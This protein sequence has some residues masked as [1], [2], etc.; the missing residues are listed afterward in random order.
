MQGT[1]GRTKTRSQN[2]I[3]FFTVNVRSKKER[4]VK[5][6]FIVRFSSDDLVEDCKEARKNRPPAS[7]RCGPKKIEPTKYYTFM[8]IEV[9]NPLNTHC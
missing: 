3:K 7:A 9:K 6:R 2:E 4:E 1:N 5:E 8:E